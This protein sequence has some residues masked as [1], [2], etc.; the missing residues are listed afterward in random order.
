MERKPLLYEDVMENL[1]RFVDSEG[2]QPGEQFPSE[3][4]LI[5]KWDISRNVLREAFHI[6]EQRGVITSKQGRG[7]FLNEFPYN[8]QYREGE[9]V[10]KALERCSLIEIYEV[11]QM[12]E[13]KACGL[14]AGRASAEDIRD[15]EQCYERMQ[16]QF[17]RTCSTIGE[18]EIHQMYLERCG[19]S[20]LKLCCDDARAKTQDMMSSTFKEILKRQDVEET[21]RS[22]R[23]I[24]D[25]I[26]Q[27]DPT[28]AEMAMSDHIETTIRM[29]RD[30]EKDT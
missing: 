22:H 13:A 29:I 15:L 21:L 10:A 14:L 25:A 12:L 3:R 7:R 9:G 20:Y 18:F 2:L 26:R 16:Q 27:K 17:R 23:K 24:L 30:G 5:Q 28:R 1:Y 8:Y 19:N 6:L 11:R 4:V